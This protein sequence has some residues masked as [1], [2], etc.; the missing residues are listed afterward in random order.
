M[1][2]TLSAIEKMPVVGSLLEGG[3]HEV[4]LC[5]PVG[6]EVRQLLE[7]LVQ[8]RPLAV[9]AGARNVVDESRAKQGR[10]GKVEGILSGPVSF[11]LFPV[12]LQAANG[13][14]ETRW[15]ATYSEPLLDGVFVVVVVA[16]AGAVRPSAP[17]GRGLSCPGLPGQLC[18]SLPECRHGRWG[19]ERNRSSI[20]GGVRRRR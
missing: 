19:R 1:L 3:G 8:C 13:S 14:L 11:W 15:L 6:A 7:P 18:C 12:S 5:L 9:G 10:A 2:G 4:V 17:D 20:G 16:V